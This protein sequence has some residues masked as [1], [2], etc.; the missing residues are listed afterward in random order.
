MKKRAGKSEERF[1]GCLLVDVP[2][3]GLQTNAV[4]TVPSLGKHTPKHFQVG[5]MFR[6]VSGDHDASA[7]FL[8]T[9]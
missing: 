3:A 9:I 8:S 5:A 6:L 7:V 2:T 1:E 4:P